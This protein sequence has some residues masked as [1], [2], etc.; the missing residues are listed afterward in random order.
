MDLL[1]RHWEKLL[2]TGVLLGVIGVTIWLSLRVGELTEELQ[3]GRRNPPAKGKEVAVIDTEAYQRAIA[4]L[5]SPLQWKI[6][7]RDP[8]QMP[9]IDR[10]PVETNVPPDRPVSTSLALLRVERVPFKMNF[11]AYVGEGRNFQ[12]DF[13]FRPRTF[14]VEKVGD[15]IKDRFE[16][17]GYQV[18]KFERKATN[19]FHSSLGREVTVDVSELTVQR[20]GE[21]PVVLVLNREAEEEEPVATLRCKPFMSDATTFRVRRGQQFTCAG[22]T[23][24]VVDITFNTVIIAD[25]LTEERRTLLLTREG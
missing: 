11:K 4:H 2:L 14:F 23:Y 20:P 7:E 21:K 6:A 5:Q 25:I 22:K 9:Q 3:Q 19:V 10:G 15:V 1:R 18:I 8:F 13:K 12:I 16:D 24:K 17:T